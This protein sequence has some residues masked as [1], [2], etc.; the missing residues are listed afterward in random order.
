V[1]RAVIP[2]ALLI[3][4]AGLLAVGAGAAAWPVLPGALGLLA[5]VI[6]I[7]SMNAPWQLFGPAL[8]RGPQSSGVVALTFDDGPDPEF[9]PAVLDALDA[10]GAKGTFFVVGSRVAAAPEVARGIVERGHQIG[11]HS[12]DHQWTKMFSRARLREDYERGARAIREAAGVVPRFFRPPVGIVAPEVLDMVASAGATVA[13]W[14][15]RPFDGRIN[16]APEVRRR[17]ASKISAGDIVLLHDGSLRPGRVPPAVAA[18]PGILDDLKARNLRSVTLAEM[19]GTAAYL[20]E[21]EL[22]QPLPLRRSPLPVVVAATVFALIL[23]TAISAQAADLPT[24]LITAAEELEKHPTVQAK[25]TQTKTSVLFVEPIVSTGELLLRR[26]DGRIRWSYD[27]GPAILL[28]DGRVYPLGS[29]EHADG[30]VLP[31]GT[32]FTAMFDALLTLDPEALAEHF[33]GTDLGEGRFSLVPRS[34]GARALFVRVELTIAG[35]PR[36]LQR[37]EM[38][39]VTGDVTLIEFADVK[40]GVPLSADRFATPAERS[41]SP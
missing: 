4:W 15:V 40:P 33:T 11:H 25:F 26:S 29:D 16:D 10:V 36:V 3:C 35:S 17:V 5:G 19:T 32:G 22:T 6:L 7:A 41:K 12:Y 9:T 34:D 1:H 14:S 2:L 20:T 31:G 37:V 23:G 8:V 27:G 38:S 24:T 39:E 18:L 30:I 21:T 13:T 28:A